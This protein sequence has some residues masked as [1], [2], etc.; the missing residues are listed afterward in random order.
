MWGLR[1]GSEA[2]AAINYSTLR[3]SLMGQTR[4]F[5]NVRVRS[6]YPVWSKNLNGRKDGSC[7]SFHDEAAQCNVSG[8]PWQSLYFSPEPYGHGSLQPGTGAL[9]IGCRGSPMVSPAGARR[10]S[11]YAWML[12]AAGAIRSGYCGEWILADR[13]DSTALCHGRFGAVSRP[14][15]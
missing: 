4:R 5:R 7:P 6:T 3:M 9:W 2:K 11:Q 8:A 15:S 14:C 1:G 12:W 10:A 13:M